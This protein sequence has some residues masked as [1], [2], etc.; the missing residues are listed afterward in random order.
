M[1]PRSAATT[2]LNVNSLKP[3]MEQGDMAGME[4]IHKIVEK[5]RQGVYTLR[6]IFSLLVKNTNE[7]NVSGVVKA[8][9]SDIRGALQ[10][11][12]NEY[13]LE[14]GIQIRDS[15]ELPV[16]TI[17]ILKKAIQQE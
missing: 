9:P 6:E 2:C 17:V 7:Q 15:A 16:S 3:Y 10:K 8:L 14:G 12:L 11:W 5:H 4:A 13:P 1:S